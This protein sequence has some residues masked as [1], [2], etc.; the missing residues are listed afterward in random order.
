MENSQTNKQGDTMGKVATVVKEKS[1]EEMMDGKILGVMMGFQMEN[2]F[3]ATLVDVASTIG[4]QE[5][6][7]SFRERWSIL[8]NTRNYIGP[9]KSGKGGFQLTEEGLKHAPQSDEYKEMMKDLSF[10]SMTNKDKQ[11]RIKKHLKKTKSGMIFD[12]LNEYGSLTTDDLAAI[13]GQNKRSHT[14][15]YSLKELRDKGYVEEDPDNDDSKGKK[16]RLSDKSYLNPH[17]RLDSS[18][19]D[20][21]KLQEKIAEG[22]ETIKSRMTGP[23]KSKESKAVKKEE[24]TSDEENPRKTKILKLMKKE[25]D[26]NENKKDKDGATSVDNEADI[27]DKSVEANKVTKKTDNSKKRKIKDESSE[28]ATTGCIDTHQRVKVE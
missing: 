16:F 14:F 10:K 20:S 9:S 25:A 12:F 11:D 4:C 21:K 5:R 8:K 13:V 22:N 18:D 26:A 23:R 1:K 7:K 24:D 17:D 3:N 15:H 2:N 27:V 6:T 28:T 19:I